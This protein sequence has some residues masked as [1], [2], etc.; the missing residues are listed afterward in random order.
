MEQYL[1][2]VVAIVVVV[3]LAYIKPKM[4]TK[5]NCPQGS[6]EHCSCDQLDYLWVA[7]AGIVAGVLSYYLFVDKNSYMKI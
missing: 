5:C 1:P 7:A 4:F 6:A 3:V 2:A